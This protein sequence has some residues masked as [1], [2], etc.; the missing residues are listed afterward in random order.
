MKQLTAKEVEQK[1]IQGEK[2]HI[3]DVREVEEI[4]NGKIPSAINIPLGLLPFRI[5]ELDK[6]KE[7]IIVCRSGNR[8][9]MATKYLLEQGYQAVN[10]SGGMLEWQGSVE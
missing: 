6:Q 1:L 5:Q 7:Y 2:L 3:I 10:M 4:Q 8:S 9:L